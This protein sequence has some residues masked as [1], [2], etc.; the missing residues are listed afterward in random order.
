M[1]RIIIFANGELPDLE[2][3]R[4]ISCVMTITSSAADG[5]T[6][7]ASRTWT[8]SPDRHHRRHGF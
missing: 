6:R 2:K 7:H 3:A 4:A 8:S 1:Q 5:G